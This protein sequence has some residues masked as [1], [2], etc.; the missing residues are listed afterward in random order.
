[1]LRKKTWPYLA[2]SLTLSCI[3]IATHAESELSGY[4]GAQSRWFYDTSNSGKLNYS[5]VAEPEYYW[6]SGN[7]SINISLFSR[8]DSDDTKR[9][10]SDI[11]ELYWLH[12]QDN[13]EIRVGV[14]KVFW[15]VT[16]SNHLVD[17]INQTDAVDSP[18]G[19]Q[20]LGQAMVQWSVAG[21]W[22]TFDAF[23]LPYFRE[24]VF[25]GKDGQLGLP[26]SIDYSETRYESDKE[27]QHIDLAVRYS[28]TLGN[29]DMGV[30]HFTGTN[31][32]PLFIPKTM[33]GTNPEPFT[34][35]FIP[36]YTQ[37]SQ[38]GLAVQ[39]T[40]DA[41]LLKLEFVYKDNGIDSYNAFV[42]GFE[43]TF[44]G[45]A[46]GPLDLGVLLEVNGDSRYDQ[47]TTV[48]QN[49]LFVGSRLAFNDIQDTSILIGMTQDLSRTQ[50][51]TALI[52]GR[53]RLGESWR[54]TLDA[55]GF[56]IDDPND[57]IYVFNSED[58]VSA[59][60]EYYF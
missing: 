2:L 25:P 12:Y 33:A 43:Y 9:S 34:P 20:K 13:W 32:E 45:L 46:Q 52:E 51:Y 55:R 41:W 40:L 48:F 23:V 49:D 18:D 44:F 50:N 39:G 35:E 53:R 36:Y 42:G 22:G 26:F 54:L 60:L 4:I 56:S 19:E 16:E 58:Y 17:V 57:A 59:T 10:H 24:R 21:N 37:L 29:W 28:Q 38:T 15:G 8:L 6:A 31:R 5:I 11:R 14:D 1:M 30:S 7:N 47:A 27:Q 3:P